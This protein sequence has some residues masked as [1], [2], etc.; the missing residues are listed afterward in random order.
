MP[1][2]SH[3]SV[4]E[5]FLR[6]KRERES[7]SAQ[8]QSDYAQ[9]LGH[10]RALICEERPSGEPEADS[11]DWRSRIRRLLLPGTGRE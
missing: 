6:K 3:R 10:L 1:G 4:A 7:Q 2:P 5:E 9:N 11:A 8:M